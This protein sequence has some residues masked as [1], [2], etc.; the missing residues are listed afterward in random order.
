MF[1]VALRHVS[2]KKITY[3]FTYNNGIIAQLSKFTKVAR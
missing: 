2:V 3:L 1:V